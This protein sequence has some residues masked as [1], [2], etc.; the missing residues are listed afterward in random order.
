MPRIRKCTICG[1]EFLSYHGIEVCSDQCRIERKHRQDEKGNIRRKKHM[2]NSPYK[3]VCPICGAYFESL[4]N[5]YCSQECSNTARINST[6]INSRIYYLSHTEF[7]KNKVL[8]SK[9][10]GSQV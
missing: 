9:K 10:M 1:C 3:K 7:V 6:K 8:K 5:K 2:S 4:N